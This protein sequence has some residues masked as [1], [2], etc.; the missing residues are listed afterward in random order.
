MW[1]WRLFFPKEQTI[2]LEDINDLSV[3]LAKTPQEVRSDLYFNLSHQEFGLKERDFSEQK[4]HGKF[5]ELKILLDKKSWGA[6]SWKKCLKLPLKM[7]LTKTQLLG[8]LK[9]E[10]LNSPYTSQLASVRQIIEQN[11]GN[12]ILV[13]KKR[14]QTSAIYSLDSSTWSFSSKKYYF[15]KRGQKSLW[16][17]E[18]QLTINNHSW[19]SIA[20]EGKDLNILNLFMV[21]F[22]SKY[23]GA[24]MGY[25][26][27]LAKVSSKKSLF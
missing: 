12:K 11:A 13:H 1:E 23:S 19:T 10:E 5:L 24:V 7:E 15:A 21:S 27:F 22:L 14:K 4:K 20:I 9:Q 3:T 17:E 6:E 16:F 2:T 8:L 25:P 18:T 26:E